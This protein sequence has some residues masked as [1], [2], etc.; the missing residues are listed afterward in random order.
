MSLYHF[1][2]GKIRVLENNLINQTD[3][4]RMVDAPDFTTAFKVLSDTD[5]GAHL[6]ELQPDQFKLALEAEIAK[7]RELMMQWIDD[8]ELLEFMFLQ[9]DAHNV[10]LFLKYKATETTTQLKDAIS[11][12][13]LSDAD[14]IYKRIV[15]GQTDV[16]VHSATE[17]LIQQVLEELDSESNGFMIDSVVDRVLLELLQERVKGIPSILIR[18]L[19]TIQQETALLK[20]FLRAK[21]MGKDMASMKSVLPDQ[22]L[23]QYELDEAQVLV[24]LSLDPVIRE[25]FKSYLEHKLLWQL[26]KDLEEAELS[27]IRSA[28]YETN[29]AVPV[30]GYFYGQQNAARNV[31]LILTAKQNEIPAE[32][33]KERVRQLY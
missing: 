4:D 13:G 29:G 32:K 19:F 17:Q 16:V 33:I 8:S 7:V 14:A 21:R 20:T 12:S 10:K 30:V 15:D 25:A 9:Y 6:Y 23:R 28:K 3:V 5:Y 27:V 24:N 11:Q 1:L 26:E 18:K 2:A 31:R 22:W